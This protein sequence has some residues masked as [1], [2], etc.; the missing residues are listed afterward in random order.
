MYG[1]S[2]QPRKPMTFQ[3][4]NATSHFPRDANQQ[5]ARP[6]NPRTINRPNRNINYWRDNPH[7]NPLVFLEITHLENPEEIQGT[8]FEYDNPPNFDDF[9]NEPTHESIDDEIDEENFQIAVSEE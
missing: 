2:V 7:S 5:M 9:Q 8:Y 1:L 6:S 3:S 4:Q